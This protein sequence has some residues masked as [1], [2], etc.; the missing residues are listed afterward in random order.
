MSLPLLEELDRDRRAA[1]EAEE[2]ELNPKRYHW[3]R[4][5]FAERI[6]DELGQSGRRSALTLGKVPSALLIHYLTSRLMLVIEWWVE[7]GSDLS[8][9]EVNHVFRRLVLRVLEPASAEV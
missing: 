7:S 3:L 2:G 4:K 6:A 9:A 5:S 1:G 8:P